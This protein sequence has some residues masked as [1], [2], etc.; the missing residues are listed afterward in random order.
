VT[1]L[2][3]VY[4]RSWRSLIGTFDVAPPAEGSC[5]QISPGVKRYPFGFALA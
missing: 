2:D 4:R 5:G 1:P 3:D